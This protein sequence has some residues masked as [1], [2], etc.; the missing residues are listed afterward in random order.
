MANIQE[1]NSAIMFGDFTNEQLDSIINSIKFRRASLV[2]EAKRNVR[3]GSSVRFY[4]TKRGQTF[5]GT[6]SKVAVKYV[7]V[8]T[9]Q[10]LWRVPASMLE[11]A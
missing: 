10:G 5:T 3:V 9:S 1:V 11:I 4:S 8:S 6:V 2:K 7:T